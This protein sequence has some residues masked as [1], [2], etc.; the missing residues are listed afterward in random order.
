M[1]NSQRGQKLVKLCDDVEK[2]TEPIKKSE[3]RRLNE[4][5]IGIVLRDASGIEQWYG[6]NAWI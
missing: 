4:L 1:L 2:K 3:V 6:S 5:S